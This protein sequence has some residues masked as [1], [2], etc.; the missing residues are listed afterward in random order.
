LRF[1]YDSGMGHDIAE[2]VT[3]DDWIRRDAI[4][5][6][7]DSHQSLDAAIDRLVMALDESVQVLGLGEPMHGAPEF[8]ALR[9]RLFH[10]LV[11]AHGFSAIAVES[12]FPRSR[13]VNQYVS[14]AE[15]RASYD[16]VK[17]NGF[18]H[19]FGRDAMNR[20][21]VEWMRAYNAGQP[22][23]GELR[24]YGFDSPTEM[25]YSDSPR[26]LVEFVL[27][28]LDVL[29]DE[30]IDRRKRIDGLLGDDGP[31]ENQEAA[32]DPSKSI[33]LTPAA[34]ALRI[35]VEEL[36]SEL[37]VRRPEL[38]VATGQD[39][40]R[41][42]VQY[43]LLSRQMLTY[44]AH[45]ARPDDKRIA[46]LL[47]MRDVMMA[48]NLM[49]QVERERSR[50]PDGG[51]VLAFAHNGHLQRGRM[52]W[53]LGPE[54]GARALEWWPAG[55]QLGMILGRGYAAIGCGVGTSEAHGLRQPETGTLEAHLT[56]TSG[57]GRFIPTRGGRQLE[58]ATIAGIRTRGAATN[59]TY[60]S[61]ASK[62]LTD[63]DWLAVLDS[64]A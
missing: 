42:A 45:V 8:L 36:A 55:A 26:R 49:Y 62:S 5:F 24:F 51:R 53:Q 35:E 27:D 59:S 33:G 29:G 57:P 31:W 58:A 37:S 7:M 34:S 23:G 1:G 48:D 19:G 39:R 15:G 11:E 25:M 2:T 52:S 30:N 44:H 10:R 32:F 63:F 12:S 13:L 17:E 6:D 9:N 14:D 50:T 16:D 18:S 47:G 28:Y 4:P 20:E 43:A 40:Y 3:V 41:E 46:V 64:I 61:L 21:L 38:V 56:S 60:F 22:N 54:L